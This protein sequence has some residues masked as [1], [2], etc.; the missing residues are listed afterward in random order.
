M[1]S[2][3]GN[4][5]DLLEVWAWNAMHDGVVGAKDSKSCLDQGSATV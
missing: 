1:E 4:M 5:E 3:L 2:V